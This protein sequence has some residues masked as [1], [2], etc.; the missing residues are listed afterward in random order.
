MKKLIY[1]IIAFFISYPGAQSVVIN[2][3][4][5]LNTY[6]I[7][8][9][10]HEYSDWIELYNRSGSPVNLKGFGL[11]DDSD[12]LFRWQF[13]EIILQPSR[14][15]LIFASDKD[16]KE[17]ISHWETI[18]NSGDYWRYQLGNGSIPSN[19]RDPDFDDSS[20]NL[21]RSGFGYGD[22]DDLTEIAQNTISVFLRSTISIDNITSI[23][24]AVL[25]VDYDD[26]FVAYLNGTEIAR[27]NIGTPGILPAWD[28]AAITGHEAV[29]YTG[30]YP[31]AFYFDDLIHLFVQGENVVVIEVHNYNTSSS[32][33]TL[34]PF[35]T[36]GLKQPPDPANGHPEILRLD[37]S[38]LHT[39][40]KL[41]SSGE[42]IIL[43]DSNGVVWDSVYTGEIPADLSRGRPGDLDTSFY[44]LS[45]ATPGMPNVLSG[46]L[47]YSESPDFSLSGGYYSQP[48]EVTLS[49]PGGEG[50]IRYTLD[51]NEPNT[52]SA[53][54]QTPISI[55][56]TT[57]LRARTFNDNALPSKI[58]THSY[59]YYHETGLPI[60]SLAT[61]S[62]NLWDTD[63]GIY[64]L[65]D[66]YEQGNPYFGAN[67]WEDW[68]RP[69]HIEIFE[70]DGTPSLRMDAGTKIHGGWSRARPQKS[71]SFF[72]R[73]RYGY[74]SIEYQ[75]FPDRDF[76]SYQA[77]LLRNSANDWDRSKFADGLM[78]G[79]VETL[80]LEIQAFRPC[81]LF[82]NGQY[83]GV[84]NIREKQNE[85]YLASYFDI[86]PDEIDLLED[87]RVIIEGDDI[88]YN[89]LMNFISNED[90]SLPENYSYVKSLMDVDNYITY[91][92]VQIYF[93]NRDWPG[94]NIKYWRP[95]TE[96]GRWRWILFDTDW[97]FGI[98][99]YNAGNA[100]EYNTLEFA[101][102]P[103]QMTFANPPWATL[104]LR[105]LLVNEEFRINFINRFADHMNTIF[106]PDRVITLID[107]LANM[108]DDE[109][110]Y[111]Y[112]RWSEPVW[113]TPEYLHWGS[114]NQ[115]YGYVDIHREFAQNRSPHMKSHIITKFNLQ[116]NIK[117]HFDV[118]PNGA[119]I[120][121]VNSII[122]DE[123]PWS[124][125]YFAGNPVKVRAIPAEGFEFDDWYGGVSNKDSDFFHMNGNDT[126]TALFRPINYVYSNIAINE[127]N[128]NPSTAINP[129]EW[130]ELYNNADYSIDLSGWTFSD[131]NPSHIFQITDNII[132]NPDEYLVLCSDTAYF[133]QVFPEVHNYLGD[134]DFGLSNSGERIQI[135][136][137]LAYIVDSVHYGI[138]TPWP[139][140]PNG[141]GATLELDDPKS[142]NSL[143]ENW[144][145]STPYGTPG[146]RNSKVST[147]SQRNLPIPN[148]FE[149]KQNFP[150]PFNSSTRIQYALPT[151]SRVVISIYNILGQKIKTFEHPLLSAGHHTQLWDGIN[152][153][154]EAVSSGLYILSFKAL[155]ITG[156]N[157]Q[158]YSETSKMLLLK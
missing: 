5:S 15:L 79:L 70:S 150:N 28:E 3:V 143:S 8:D 64:V 156:S 125:N 137:I 89:H 86:D 99:A 58:I 130:L 29:M 67:F 132:L 154:G 10:D 63:Y 60:V 19:W 7:A 77:F 33:L 9:E 83:W 35:L 92:A 55:S 73:N 12:N 62:V 129:G 65:G 6:T 142:D 120:V 111:N 68:E 81:V 95:K 98:N 69:V 44:Y 118:Q 75:L 113:W 41:K 27:A 114:F 47:G 61:D 97:G 158:E 133:H 18:I 71:M 14:H 74:P 141:T 145:S 110:Y 90:I 93:D 87:N 104:M 26:A 40:F 11:S 88:H 112:E 4:M 146:E 57:V 127:I 155:S 45:E 151:K 138:T 116:G 82:L 37:Q 21:G 80:D 135:S 94:N 149:V 22:N 102:S 84:M 31:E 147:L 107:S 148:I 2:E 76:T 30:G 43:S 108:L 117:V 115:W 42:D 51:G 16:R 17:I 128:Y 153:T 49:S 48:I 50:E 34:I 152:E 39:N 109:M 123:Y 13:P 140:E 121:K 105:R 101:T 134:F 25:H 144:S 96:N 131:E 139:E 103:T 78:Q 66:S 53:L 54:F 157:R 36:L 91:Q 136:N 46:Y 100:Y 72:A 126:L 1:L 122:P 23:S 106:Q 20:W 38:Y 124:G 32:D 119:G 24:R 85:D 56:S 52:N 59:I